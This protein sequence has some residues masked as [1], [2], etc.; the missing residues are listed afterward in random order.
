MGAAVS[1][2]GATVEVGSQHGAGCLK[3]DRTEATFSW[4]Q[5]VFPLP[6]LVFLN[7]NRQTLDGALDGQP[8]LAR[9]AAADIGGP[10]SISRAIARAAAG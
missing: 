5:P 9:P 10:C 1:A 7:P 3:C 8:R 6:P 4:N 2:L